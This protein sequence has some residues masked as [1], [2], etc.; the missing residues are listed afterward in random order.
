MRSRLFSLFRPA[1]LG[2]CALAAQS[3]LSE[4]F[5]FR[6]ECKDETS[7][8][9]SGLCTG[10]ASDYELRQRLGE[11]TFA[12]VR[13]ATHVRTGEQLA[14]KLV[15]KKGTCRKEL[16]HEVAVLQ[17]VGQHKHIVCL[18]DTFD[19]EDAWALVLELVSGGEVFDRVVETGHFSERDAAAIVRQVASALMHI[20]RRGIVHRDLKPENLLLVS[21]E[22]DADV[23]LCDFGLSVFT[24]EG[25]P[26]LR[27]V[28]GTIAYMSPEQ[29]RGDEFG[30]EVDLWALGV[31][32]YLLLVGY[33]PFDP[34]GMADDLAL[35]RAIL[36]HKYDGC[37]STE[38]A[39]VS[40]EARAVVRLL[41]APDPRERATVRQL[42]ASPWVGADAA[43]SSA[44]T[45]P[46]P[47][48]ERLRGFNEARKTWRTAIRAAALIGRAPSRGTARGAES[49]PHGALEELQAA[50]AAYDTDGSGTIEAD[51]L[52]TAMLSLGVGESAA[53]ERTLQATGH[54]TGD[55]LVI[56]FDDFV[57]AVGPVYEHSRVALR[58]AFDI[59]D[60]DRSGGI[61]KAEL[62][63]FLSK[64]RMLPADEAEGEAAVEA[65][66]AQADVNHD[67]SISF[68]EFSRLFHDYRYNSVS[69]AR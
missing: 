22:H 12:E 3:S 45:E 55:D 9:E 24:G 35:S 14:C 18:R 33:H 25:A 27:G 30:S 56:S 63:S 41:L 4:N 13:L 2:G 51:E 19:T 66:W 58:R 23:K 7:N 17:A 61:D 31:I 67:G 43:S 62:R 65:M 29:L 21:G 54:R 10:D 34:A 11:G 38:W 47:V 46:L 40:P 6:R 36:A 42:L 5:L 37:S 44:A 39:S 1:A 69:E 8:Q 16:E 68:D 53:A 52:R 48:G 50:F 49:L 28:V 20:H 32:L 15:R 60:A 59:F 57:A 64:L 26:P